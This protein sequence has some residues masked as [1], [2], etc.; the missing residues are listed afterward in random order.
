MASGHLHS[1]HLENDKYHHV[2]N[3]MF[4]TDDE[5][6]VIQQSLQGKPIPQERLAALNNVKK[7]VD[8][9]INMAIVKNTQPKIERIDGEEA[10]EEAG[11][12]EK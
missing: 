6:F 2:F 8:E 5:V 10:G 3:L 4:M 12:A 1:V 9:I 11:E 7:S